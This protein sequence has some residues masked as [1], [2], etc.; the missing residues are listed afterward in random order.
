MAPSVLYTSEAVAPNSV[1][2]CAV[3]TSATSSTV[4]VR[5]RAA[6]SSWSRAERRANASDARTEPGCVS[7]GPAM[8][9]EDSWGS[10]S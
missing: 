6:A 4:E 8:R 2:Q 5:V 3:T 10:I 7:A 9:L 1:P